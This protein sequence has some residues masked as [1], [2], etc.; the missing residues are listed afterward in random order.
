MSQ[1]GPGS[2]ADHGI[3]AR[4]TL[5]EPY[6][7]VIKRAK[8][9]A[10]TDAPTIRDRPLIYLKDLGWRLAKNRVCHGNELHG[11]IVGTRDERG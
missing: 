10:E 6:L 2:S 8:T 7:T 11:K 9:S 4:L 3:G 1:L 5:G